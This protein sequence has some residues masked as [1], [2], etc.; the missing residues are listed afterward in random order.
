MCEWADIRTWKEQEQEECQEQERFKEDV[1]DQVAQ[2][3]R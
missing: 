3:N 2:W 1:Q